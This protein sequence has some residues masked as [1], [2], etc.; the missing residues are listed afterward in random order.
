MFVNDFHVNDDTAVFVENVHHV[1]GIF[2]VGKFAVIYHFDSEGG[3]IFRRIFIEHR[4]FENSSV[5]VE[6]FNVCTFPEVF[7]GNAVENNIGIGSRNNALDIFGRR[8]RCEREARDGRDRH[9][10]SHYSRK[11]LFH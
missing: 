1:I 6:Y 5:F 11:D 7:V 9:S 4:F 8:A 10:G 2:I 3:K